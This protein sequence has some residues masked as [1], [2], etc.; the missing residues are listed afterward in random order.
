[1]SGT[2]RASGN[3][4]KP[5]N[6]NGRIVFAAVAT[7]VLAVGVA[8]GA[9]VVLN[10]GGEKPASASSPVATSEEA[11][12]IPTPKTG[13]AVTVTTPDGY[14]YKIAAAGASRRPSGEAYIDYTMVNLGAERAPLE[15]PGTLYIAKAKA[16]DTLKTCPNQGQT[17]GAYCTPT[18]QS[19]VWGYLGTSRQPEIDG[20]DQWMPPGAG[21]LVR[22]STVEK[23]GEL[24]SADLALFITAIRFAK[25]KTIPVPLP[26]G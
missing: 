1:M 4:R 13:P 15:S 10:S 23:S 6:S 25:G 20:E 5:K 12:A 22:V 17:E 11:G 9:V 24:T 14:R 19:E 16:G 18:T 21:Y 3:R 2:R 26:Q 7:G 8:A